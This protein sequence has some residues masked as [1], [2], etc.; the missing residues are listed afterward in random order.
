MTSNTSL[1]CES[2]PAL[3]LLLQGCVRQAVFCCRPGWQQE[4]CSPCILSVSAVISIT[5]PGITSPES[6]CI[7]GSTR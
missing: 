1:H 2:A 5:H 4:P 3:L 6:S 7:A